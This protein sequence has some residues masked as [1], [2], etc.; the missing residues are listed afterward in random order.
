MIS[1]LPVVAVIGDA[2]AVNL[3]YALAFLVRFGGRLPAV[4]WNSYTDIAAWIT[5]TTIG[6]FY[7]YGLY[8]F[9]R[10]QLEELVA[11]IV[12]SVT[13]STMV[14]ISLSYMLQ[15][16]AFP[17]STLLMA[18]P[19][20]LTICGT[21]RC[22]LWR[23]VH[24]LLGP[25]VLIVIGSTEQAHA[26]AEKLQRIDPRLC[27]VAGLITDLPVADQLTMDAPLLGSYKDVASALERVQV[28]SILVCD[29]VPLELRMTLVAEA[30]RRGLTIFLVPTLYELRLANTRLE[31]LGGMPTF[32][33]AQPSQCGTY[34]WKRIADVVLA[35]M[36]AVPALALILIAA[37]AIKIESPRG[38]TFYRQERIGRGGRV[39]TLFK[40]RTMVPDAEAMTGPVLA[41][42]QDPRIT[43]VGRVLRLTR[44]D[45]LPQLWNVLK[46]DMSFI[47][48][49]PERPVFVRQFREQV[50]QYD[51][52][53]AINS[54]ITGLAQ[55]V[56]NYDTAA[57]DKL[58]YD[59]LYV[60]RL[61]PFLDL[62]I[63]LH[64]LKVMIMPN[65]S[66]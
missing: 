9:K 23:W 29:D 1:W 2:L 28:N 12:C 22:L 11:S 50:P 54:G 38:S 59:L 8:Q 32:C 26:R 41:K 4:N 46:G 44:I 62:Q 7:A 18:A 61:S 36:F 30:Q 3:S 27:Q 21:W 56:G 48:P 35:L 66:R 39:F 20:A 49:R 13:I 43:R 60:Q 24:S 53:H 47:G 5:L 14:A 10:R 34:P 58:L 19:I 16:Y 55:V 65:K 51:D 6:L 17:R 52:R 64:T 25:L 33:L 37:V 45:E 31:Q 57:S 63:L 40:L 42:E 15:R